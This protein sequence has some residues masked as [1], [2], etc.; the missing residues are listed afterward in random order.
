M[1]FKPGTGWKFYIGSDLVGDI[2]S[3]DWKPTIKDE[4]TAS[5]G[6]AAE[7]PLPSVFSGSI[8]LK[9]K[10][11]PEDVGQA[12]LIAKVTT[13]ALIAAATIIASGTKGSGSAVGWTGA[14]VI[15]SYSP[16]PKWDS[17][18]IDVSFDLKTSGTW[19][20]SSTL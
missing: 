14:C 2:Q 18:A 9:G 1:A 20:I 11:N 17:P 15:N 16:S 12:A 6:D 3:M 7:E 8:S 5:F 13:P 19:P 4:E 10:F